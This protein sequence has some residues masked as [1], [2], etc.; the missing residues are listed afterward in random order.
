[1]E[2]LKVETKS[3]PAF[4]PLDMN[5][6]KEK[7]GVDCSVISRGREGATGAQVTDKNLG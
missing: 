2:S 1:M 4:L 6:E 7:C 3:D 5:G